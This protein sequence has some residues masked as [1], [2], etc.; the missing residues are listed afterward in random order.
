MIDL[1]NAAITDLLGNSM[2]HNP[3]TI[4]IG[5]AIL[6]E[7]RR[8]LDLADRTRLM[9]G[10][11]TLPEEILD[12]LAVELRTPFYDQAFPLE[13]KREL[14][15]KTLLWY[16]RAGTVSAVM[17]LVQTIFGFGRVVEWFDFTDPP[18]TPGTFDIETKATL[19]EDTFVQFLRIIRKVK[20]TRSHLR[21]VVVL[22]S[23]DGAQYVGSAV[24]TKRFKTVI[25]NNPAVDQRLEA[26]LHSGS[27][28]LTRP[29]IRIP[30]ESS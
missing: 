12:V 20:N 23:V 15:R 21:R 26:K 25:W 4:S 3:E 27:V 13:T 5:Y 6:M 22:R 29:T 18:F 14:V 8:L 11:D 10:I 19:T 30:A 9:A 2:R 24:V 28:T 17:D 7:K 1:R 16:M